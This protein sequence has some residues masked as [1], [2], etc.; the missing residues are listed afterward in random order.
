MAENNRNF[1]IFLL[2][3]S[4][5]G[6]ALFYGC[7]S[8]A[9]SDKIPDIEYSITGTY[10]S[11]GLTSFSSARAVSG[12]AAGILIYSESDPGNYADIDT[13]NRTYI[14]RNLR[15]GNHYIVF[16]HIPFGVGGATYICRSEQPVVLTETNPVQKCNELKAVECNV[17]MTGKLLSSTGQP[18]TPAPTISLWGQTIEV[19][20]ITGEFTTPKMPEGTTADLVINAINYKQTTNTV[21][22]SNN[23]AYHEITAVET[24]V[25]NIP[26]SVDVSSKDSRYNANSLVILTAE[27]EDNGNKQIEFS[28]TIESCTSPNKGELASEAPIIRNGKHIN[29]CYWYSPSENCLATITVTVRAKDTIPELSSKAKLHLKIGD[30]DYKPNN[31]PVI[32]DTTI[33]PES[34]Y[35][36]RVYTI[37]CIATDTEMDA[38]THQLTISPSGS[39]LQKASGNTWKWTT[40]ELEET[41]SFTLN[42]EV[43]DQKGNLATYS[44][45]VSVNKSQPNEPPYVVSQNPS[46]ATDVMSGKEIT[47]KIEAKDP[48][49]EKL[50]F[51]WSTRKG[52]IKESSET[53]TSASIVWVAPY[54]NNATSTTI[55]CIISDP[56]QSSVTATFT[57]NIIPDPT[58]K[59]PEVAVTITGVSD[60]YKNTIPL[61][62]AGETVSFVGLATDSNQNVAIDPSHFTWSIDL[63][64][65]SSTQLPDKSNNSSYS[66]NAQSAKGDYS[67]RLVAVDLNGISG[68]DTVDFRINTLPET[69]IQCNG[70]IIDSTGRMVTPSQYEYTNGSQ[71]YDVF[72]INDTINLVASCSDIEST[73]TLLDNSARWVLNSTPSVGKE[74]SPTLLTKGINTVTLRTTDSKEEMSATSTYSFFV[75]TAPEFETA[76]STKSGFINTDIIKLDAKVN[77]DANGI[78]M[79]WFISYKAGDSENFTDYTVFDVSGS[80]PVESS[81]NSLSS[82]LQINASTLMALGTDFKF[83]LIATDSMGQQT[84]NDSIGFSIVVSHKIEDFVVASGTYSINKKP[85]T[86]DELLPAL[87]KPYIF[88]AKQPFSIR[89]GSD[90]WQEAMTWT[91]SDSF[92][93]NDTPGAFSKIADSFVDS[94]TLNGYSISDNFGTHTIR[95]EGKSNEYGIV[96]SNSTVIF[97]NSTPKV[98]F[99]N[100]VDGT[101]RFDTGSNATFTITLKED[102]KNEKLGLVWTIYDLDQNCQETTSVVYYSNDLDPSTGNISPVDMAGANEKNVTINWNKIS[103]SAP[104]TKGAKRVYVC[105]FD[106]YG[107]AATASVDILVN[108]LP[109]FEIVVPN[110]ERKI[111]IWVPEYSDNAEDYR[112]FQDQYATATSDIP[113]YLVSGNPSMQLKFL[114][115]PTDVEDGSLTGEKVI[116]KYTDYNGAATTASGTEIDARFGIGLNTI[117]VECRDNFYDYYKKDG[118][119]VYNNMC[120]AT[121][122]ADFYIWHSMAW[123]LNPTTTLGT[124]LYNT[125]NSGIFYV[126][127][128]NNVNNFAERYQLD[129]GVNTTLTRLVPGYVKPDIYLKNSESSVVG[130][131]TPKII[132]FIQSAENKFLM[133]TNST[134]TTNLAALKSG[135]V[136]VTYYK[137]PSNDE[138]PLTWISSYTIMNITSQDTNADNKP[139][140]SFA[141]PQRIN[142]SEVMTAPK[143]PENDAKFPEKILS[144]T[145]ADTN[146]VTAGAMLLHNWNSKDY[147]AAFSNER[148]YFDAENTVPLYFLDSKALS[149]SDYSKIRFLNK[150]TNLRQK[151]FFTDTNNNRIIRLKSDF[152]ESNTIVASKPIDICTTESK[153]VFSL[154]ESGDLNKPGISLYEIDDSKATLLTSFAKFTDSNDLKERAGKL[155]NPK[156]I[157]YHTYRSGDNYF[158]GLIIL[159]EG[160]SPTKSRIQVIRSN[161]ADWLE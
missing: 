56:Y 119:S 111:K 156:S 85:Y 59:A 73:Q 146:D 150:L 95:L 4:L 94:Y 82:N 44:R 36:S 17:E 101:I 141:L 118:Q 9:T 33:Y 149:F 37:T 125:N 103:P 74:F 6:A 159:E 148:Y 98:E 122:S 124:A 161:K 46:S 117:N 100:M 35:G 77:D 18:I 48:E 136:S 58:K 115:E 116:W 43:R 92:W 40:P 28:W 143:Y 60:Y 152:S 114:A 38:L 120:I 53:N 144:M 66:T 130:T 158:G 24:T 139:Y 108:T 78:T 13:N 127:Y 63:P 14:I 109:K 145:Y 93:T 71:K 32:I 42:F 75:N 12:P 91:W 155:K 121:Y 138:D 135:A 27:A 84:I 137:I 110:T 22:F 151:L 96:A 67:V 26:P 20:P 147:I 80:N 112:P 30:G 3:L 86:F 65:N 21:T 134:D 69:A 70:S 2:V 88:E 55:G 89:S 105:A 11:Q 5:I 31:K 83:R 62:K 45:N 47:L 90:L 1:S 25:I 160:S 140:Y 10:N 64:N 133:L 7:G 49:N 15:P 153:Y 102:N 50:T 97:I 29:Q 154:S 104:L 129:C 142:N 57:L 68:E 106:A 39:I 52:Q 157:I 107:K 34:L 19:N 99:N 126:Q 81:T 72:Q 23:P 123:E 131:I 128:G 61:F 51:N 8:S 54:L 16:K 41:K 132:T 113:V 76:T 87:E 79:T